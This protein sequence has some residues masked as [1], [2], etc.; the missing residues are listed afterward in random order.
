MKTMKT[1]VICVSDNQSNVEKVVAVAHAQSADVR[2]YTHSEWAQITNKTMLTESTQ[3]P[4]Q[5]LLPGAQIIPFPGVATPKIKRMNEVE[6]EAIE[7]AIAAFNGNLTEAAKGLGIGR[8]TLYRKLKDYNINPR[9]L[10]TNKA[11]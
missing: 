11:A 6:L 1:I 3:L 8:A 9:Q 2:T 10:K 5:S 4:T 7:V